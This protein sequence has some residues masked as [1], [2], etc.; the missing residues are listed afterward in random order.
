MIGKYLLRLVSL[1]YL[2]VLLVAPVGYVFYKTFEHGFGPAWEAVTTPAAIHALKV[3]L[4]LAAIAVPANTV[5]G[6]L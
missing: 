4:I 6:I 2:G 1:G 3:T 5:F